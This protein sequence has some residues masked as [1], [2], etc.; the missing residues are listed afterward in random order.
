MF[1]RGTTCPYISIG[2]LPTDLNGVHMDFRWQFDPS[3]MKFSLKH[4]CD[5]DKK[6]IVSRWNFPNTDEGT[7]FTSSGFRKFSVL[8]FQKEILC[9][10]SIWSVQ[11]IASQIVSTRRTHFYLQEAKRYQLRICVYIHLCSYGHNISNSAM[12]TGREK[13]YRKNW[14]VMYLF[15]ITEKLLYRVSSLFPNSD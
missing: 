15:K 1:H 3:K 12:P 13:T 10:L 9:L 4:I 7:Y 5:G 8:F 6:L 14:A 2:R 11:Q